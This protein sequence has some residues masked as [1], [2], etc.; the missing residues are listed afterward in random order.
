MAAAA[1]GD[2]FDESGQQRYSENDNSS[3][4]WSAQS[5]IRQ[6]APPP[7]RSF[8]SSLFPLPLFRTP[9]TP[10]CAA[11]WFPLFF[12]FCFILVGRLLDFS[13]SNALDINRTAESH[14]ATRVLIFCV[15]DIFIR[16]QMKA[17]LQA[18]ENPLPRK[19][20]ASP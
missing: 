19:L 15:D 8:F 2:P 1:G 14:C 17:I 11:H 3:G 13:L 12:Y 20:A 6:V 10:P 5:P 16:I 7:S 18:K 4:E 9:R